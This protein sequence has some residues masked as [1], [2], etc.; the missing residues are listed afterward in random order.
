MF[1]NHIVEYGIQRCQVKVEFSWIL[2]DKVSRHSSNYNTTNMAACRWSCDW[3]AEPRDVN[4]KWRLRKDLPKNDRNFH[5]SIHR[6]LQAWIPQCTYLV[7]K[8]SVRIVL[9]VHKTCVWGWRVTTRWG[10]TSVVSSEISTK[11]SP[12]SSALFG[13]LDTIECLRGQYLFNAG[14]VRVRPRPHRAWMTLRALV[15]RI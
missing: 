3:E 14:D 1:S 11:M 4:R 13:S 10:R 6:L 15:S 5:W 9:A 2:L 7:D 8:A 12:T